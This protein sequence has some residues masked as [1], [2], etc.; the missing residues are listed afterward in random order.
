[1]DS[2]GICLT[3]R[4][5]SVAPQKAQR[6]QYQHPLKW[7]LNQFHATPIN[8]SNIQLSHYPAISSVFQVK[9]F[10][11]KKFNKVTYEF[12]VSPARYVQ[13]PCNIH[14]VRGTCHTTAWTDGQMAL[15]KWVIYRLLLLK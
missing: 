2:N 10:Q 12:L 1:M 3:R 13:S 5:R 14:F 7:T 4:N 15:T 9:Y 8:H 11:N 6:C